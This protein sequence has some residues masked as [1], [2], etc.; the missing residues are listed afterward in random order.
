MSNILIQYA[1][2]GRPQRFL[3]G[4]DSIFDLA[5][6]KKD[7][8]IHAVLD[9]DDPSLPE[10]KQIIENYDFPI[11]ANIGSSTSKINAIN[12]KLPDVKWDILVNFSDDMR[13]TVF[14]WDTLIRDGFRC[15][16]EDFDGFCHW[17]EP[18]S[19]MSIA[20]MSI[21]G[22]KYYE[23]DGYIYHDSYLS[24]FC[25]NEAAEVSKIRG[26]Y[27]FMGLQLF[28]HLNPAYG[29][30]PRDDMFNAQQDLWNVDEINFYERK[31]KNFD[32]V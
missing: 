11:I 29:H 15:N 10:Y 31:A 28:Q 18:D 20:T 16:C 30:L 21:L 32:M 3:D 25:D 26:K 27:Y 6:S 13:F 8:I 14:G 1:S 24:L 17:P 22:R 4:L 2:R 5:A 7:I 23:R 9:H 19:G 12:R